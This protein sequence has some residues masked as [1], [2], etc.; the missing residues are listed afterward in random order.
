MGNF[1]F[2][3]KKIVGPDYYGAGVKRMDWPTFELNLLSAIDQ[4]GSIDFQ[5]EIEH[6][7][8]WNFVL[9]VLPSGADSATLE[10]TGYHTHGMKKGKQLDPE[11]IAALLS[12][13]LTQPAGEQRNWSIELIDGELEPAKLANII[14]HILEQG[15]QFNPNLIQEVKFTAK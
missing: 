9:T 5:M 8:L 14:V 2:L 13:G 6:Q 15:Y 11:L 3:K 1:K 4:M 12:M 10:A 7:H